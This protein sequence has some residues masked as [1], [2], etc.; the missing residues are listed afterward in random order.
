MPDLLASSRNNAPPPG[1]VRAAP[2]RA[3]PATTP[4]APALAVDFGAAL[5]GL[6]L[7][8]ATATAKG[9]RQSDAEGGKDLPPD[10][11]PPI[12]A[13]LAWLP[14][15]MMAI[16]L[17]AQL[18]IADPAAVPPAEAGGAAPALP[19]GIVVA[20]TPS[21]PAGATPAGVELVGPGL[22]DASGPVEIEFGQDAAPD[23]IAWRPT[24]DPGDAAIARARLDAAMRDTL[25]S[26]PTQVA[27]QPSV[28]KTALVSGV[29]AQVF[30]TALTAPEAAPLDRAGD[31]A[32]LLQGQA[33]TEQLSVVQAMS[34]TSQ[35]P[36]DLTQ[37]GW[38]GQMIDR[39]AAL[40]D[41]AEATDTRIKLAPEHLG[42][43]EVSIRRDGDRLNVHFAAENPAARQ[44]IADA[45]P[46]LADLADARGVKLGQ[47]SVDG[48]DARQGQQRAPQQPATP[49]RNAIARR[50]PE[51]I[52]EHRIA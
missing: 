38:M 19:G 35:A 52:T 47:T 25:Q 15:G 3:T 13:T 23:A 50:S 16:A 2:P 28:T 24:E 33:R 45:A 10:D 22:V 39:I 9:E 11:T 30:A 18:N 49:L 6:L 43:I 51:P 48:G 36:L 26:P 14:E 34:A 44:A 21:T 40:R 27:L 46:R 4:E 32:I 5:S 7:P 41:A 42:A 37:D 31:S 20:P 12:D 1:I 8:G 29:A 17:P